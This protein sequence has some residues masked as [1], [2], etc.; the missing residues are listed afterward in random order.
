MESNKTILVIDDDLDFQLMIGNLLRNNGFSVRTLLEGKVDTT[1]DTA[2]GCD[3]VLLDV[4][5][6]GVSGIDLG[7]ELKSSSETSNIPVILITGHS[8]PEKLFTEAQANALLK[9][10]FAL[11]GLVD[12]INELL[13]GSTM[14]S[15]QNIA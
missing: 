8:E 2:R 12:K 6:P 7:K 13:P 3:M 4:Q 11:S 14:Q 5:L 10:P 9:K 15:S 1:L